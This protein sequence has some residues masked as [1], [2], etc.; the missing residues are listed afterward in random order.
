MKKI[1]ETENALTED[2][3]ALPD[4]FE[5]MSYLA[6]TARLGRANESDRMEVFQVHGCMAELHIIPALEAEHWTF[7]CL[8][9]GSHGCCHR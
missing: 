4:V 9:R 3:M 5:R 8:H 6:A 2:L 1:S 7:F